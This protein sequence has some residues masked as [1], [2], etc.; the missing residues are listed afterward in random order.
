MRESMDGFTFVELP[1]VCEACELENQANA[2]ERMATKDP[3]QERKD[4]HLRMAA[5]FRTKAKLLSGRW[6]QCKTDEFDT[7]GTI[8]MSEPQIEVARAEGKTIEVLTEIV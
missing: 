2:R 8:D 5:R 4:A 6:F 3:N 1:P 7:Y